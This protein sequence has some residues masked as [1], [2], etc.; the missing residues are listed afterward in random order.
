MAV[1]VVR[2]DNAAR[3]KFQHTMMRATPL[4]VSV[5]IWRYTH[6]MTRRYAVSFYSV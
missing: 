3:F 1:G 6:D 5:T 2:H 4:S